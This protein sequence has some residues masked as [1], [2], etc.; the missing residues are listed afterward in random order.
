M[1]IG[2][3][4][5]IAHSLPPRSYG[6][7]E[8]IASVLTEGF[9][10]RGHEVTLFASADSHTTGTLSAVAAAGYEEDPSIEPKVNGALHIA[11]AME[12]AA[13][14]DVVLNQF[15]FTPVT[16]SRLIATPLVTT[17]HG[18]GWPEIAEVYR[19]YN[20]VAHYVAI[21][22]SNRHPDLRYAATIHHGI[23]VENFRFRSEPGAYLLFLGR[24]H[25]D[26]GTDLAIMVARQAGVPL[27]IAG[28]IQD[29]AYF[30]DKIAPQLGGSVTYLG[31]VGPA[32]RNDLLGGASALLHLIRFEEPFGLSVVEALATGTPVIATAL[33]SLPELLA[34]GTTGFL[35]TDVDQAV[36]AVAR[37]PELD[38]AACRLAAVTRFDSSRMISQYLHLF[39]TVIAGRARGRGR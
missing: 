26:K 18:L 11:A 15:D 8:Q 17:V 31:P 5:S 1:R 28:P 9:V 6:P 13:D 14:F 16:F 2:V 39:E 22:A 7:W 19:R 35:V 38:R 12:R 34:A 29:Q 25:P 10:A 37:L 20:D 30:D 21:S 32:E 4:A 27:V 23:E 36:S 33:G 24:I 3:I